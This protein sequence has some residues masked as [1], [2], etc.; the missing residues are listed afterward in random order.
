MNRSS[1]TSSK[2]D[3]KNL[4]RK[5]LV[6]QKDGNQEESIKYFDKALEFE[7]NNSELLYDKAIS[8]QM[9]L[10]FDDAVEYYNKS[11]KIGG[12]PRRGG[13]PPAPPAAKRARTRAAG[14]W[15]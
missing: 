7:P 15:R 13:A 1:D 14:T 3:I 10:R 12:C 6:L 8:F 4:H 2:N 9:L 11:L 5:A